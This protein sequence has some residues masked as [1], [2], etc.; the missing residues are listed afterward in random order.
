MKDGLLLLSVLAMML[1]GFPL[2]RW[3]D[4]LIDETIDPPEENDNA[5][6]SRKE[7]AERMRIR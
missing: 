5:P 7:E 6:D 4:R 1:A 2:M 3:I